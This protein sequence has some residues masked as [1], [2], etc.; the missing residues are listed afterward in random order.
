MAS[1]FALFPELPGVRQIFVADISEI[2]TSCGF[3][4][5]ECD[6]KRERPTLNAWAEAKGPEGLAEYRGDNNLESIDGLPTGPTVSR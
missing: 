4:I 3:G 5:P 1:I 6:L 2:Q